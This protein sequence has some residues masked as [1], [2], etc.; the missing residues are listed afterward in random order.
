MSAFSKP[1]IDIAQQLELLKQRGLQIHDEPRALCFLQAVSFFRLTPYMRPFQS[2]DDSK[3]RFRPG[4]GFRELARLYD[5]DRRL[6]LLVMDAIERVEVATRAV[7]SNHMG[8]KYG[9]HWYLDVHLFKQSYRHEALLAAIQR[10]Q[11]EAQRTYA[12]EC[13]RIDALSLPAQ[14]KAQLKLSRTKESYARHYQLTYE[15]P[16]LMPGWAA[17]EEVTLGELSHLFAG[18]NRDADKKAIARR[19]SLP[20]PLLQSWLH[21]LTVTRNICA[22]HARLWNREPGIKPELPK[23]ATVL[24]PQAIGMHGRL[25]TVLSILNHLMRQVS[26]HTSWDRRLG[27]LLSQFSEISQPAMGSPPDW[28]ADPFWHQ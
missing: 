6:R 2:P 18:L 22:H 27:E 1:A 3:H 4:T 10:K 15:K 26:P 21:C 7:I 8:P 9:A 28:Q 24:W 13:E 12:R 19:L 20:A 14:R 16:K 5:F 25:Y 23:T 17:L 11:D